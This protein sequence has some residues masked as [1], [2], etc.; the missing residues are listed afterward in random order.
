VRSLCLGRIWLKLGLDFND[1]RSSADGYP[2][3]RYIYFYSVS[4]AERRAPRSEA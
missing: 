4:I 1:E 3:G 2:L